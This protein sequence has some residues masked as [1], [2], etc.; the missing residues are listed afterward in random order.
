VPTDSIGDCDECLP[1]GVLEVD[2]CDY[3]RP[4]NHSLP[5][6]LIS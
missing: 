2:P 6:E 3:M 5:A 4:L 1:I